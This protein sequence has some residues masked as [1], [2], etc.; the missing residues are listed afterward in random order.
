MRRTVSMKRSSSSCRSREIDLEQ[1]GDGVGNLLLGHR[2]ADDLAQRRR[3]GRRAA[4]GDLVPLLAV[5]IDAENADV[6]D[7]VM[8]AGIHAAGH[9]DLDRAEVVEIVEIVEARWI[10]LAIGIEPALARPQKSRPGQQ[11]M[12][13]SVPMFGV[14]SAERVQLAARPRAAPAAARPPAPGSD[15][16]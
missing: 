5:L 6:A 11:I 14:A 4:D 3:R 12:S 1:P 16:G 15:R 8:A 9:L 10:C 7:V 2:R 13:V